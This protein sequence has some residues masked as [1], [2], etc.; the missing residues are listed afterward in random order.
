MSGDHHTLA[1]LL[2][3]AFVAVTLTITTWVSRHR[4]GTAEEFYAGGRLFSPME[5]GFALDESFRSPVCGEASCT[6]IRG[7][8][9][10]VGGTDAP[11]SLPSCA[12]RSTAPTG[13]ISR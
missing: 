13:H 10:D 4:H 8:V 1:L 12:L 5:N 6:H 9:G 7:V 3:S 11:A 2:F